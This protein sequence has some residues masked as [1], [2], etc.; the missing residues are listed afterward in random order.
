MK[1][2]YAIGT[3]DIGKYIEVANLPIIGS[4]DTMVAQL[5]RYYYDTIDI[6]VMVEMPTEML[7]AIIER[8]TTELKRRKAEG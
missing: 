3:D 1:L 5:A 6:A 2:N 8:S 7:E 4:P